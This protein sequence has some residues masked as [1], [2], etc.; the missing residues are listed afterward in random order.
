MELLNT[1]LAS[2]KNA[3]ALNEY[4]ITD[5]LGR[6]GFGQVFKAS[7]RYSGEHYAIKI[8]SKEDKKASLRRTSNLRKESELLRGIKHPNIVKFVEYKETAT[9]IFIVLEYCNGGDLLNYIERRVKH[10]GTWQ[11]DP[12]SLSWVVEKVAQVLEFLHNQ[13]MIHRDI[14]PGGH[15]LTQKTSLSKLTNL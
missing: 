3:N 1:L 10:F 5:F 9:H 13:K 8:Y 15:E 11:L 2:E 14:K 4:T 6:G 7:S 12:K